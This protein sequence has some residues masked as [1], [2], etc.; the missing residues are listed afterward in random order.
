LDKNYKLDEKE[1]C[2]SIIDHFHAT[3]DEYKKNKM[4][5]L[6]SKL[7]L[8]PSHM[9]LILKIFKRNPLMSLYW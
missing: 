5:S 6:G 7:D 8:I 3:W 2:I 9:K 4:L 1:N